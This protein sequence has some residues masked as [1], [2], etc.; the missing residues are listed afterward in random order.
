MN[1]EQKIKLV[2]L[3]GVDVWKLPVKVLCQA[4]GLVSVEDAAKLVGMK[5]P[6][7]RLAIVKGWIP[8][9]TVAVRR[10]RFYLPADVEG[11]RAAASGHRGRGRPTR[12]TAEVLADIRAMRA[13]SASQWDVAKKYGV[14][15]ATVS[16]LLQGT[17]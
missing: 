6:A 3:L 5:C 2:D 7:F 4:L 1:N 8:K 15:Q 17:A 13:A 16:R 14:D 10:R 11:L 12:W 9:P